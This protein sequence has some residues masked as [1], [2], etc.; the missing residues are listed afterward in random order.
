MDQIVSVRPGGRLAE[1]AKVGELIL[2][3]TSVAALMIGWMAFLL[4]LVAKIVI[5]FMH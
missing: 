3:G 1:V 2:G 5:A 4:W